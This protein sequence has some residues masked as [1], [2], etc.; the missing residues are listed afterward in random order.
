MRR[1]RTRIPLS[2][3]DWAAFAVLLLVFNLSACGLSRVQWG[4]D[5]HFP[6]RVHYI[7]AHGKPRAYGGGVCAIRSRHTHQWKPV[8]L[9]AFR[10]SADGYREQRTLHP[11]FSK[12]SHV[13]G[14]CYAKGWHL[15]LEPPLPHLRWNRVY[16][17]YTE[18]GHGG[19]VLTIYQGPHEPDRCLKKGCEFS[20]R[21]GHRPC[22]D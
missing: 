9:E 2:W 6:E 7:G 21:H 18:K 1:C 11:Y 12:H 3:I 14:T 13:D 20:L 16:G 5:P 4:G 19:D 10:L 17:A 15:H 22:K 8:P